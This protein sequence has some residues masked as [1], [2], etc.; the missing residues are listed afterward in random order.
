M[1]DI[2]KRLDFHK[3]NRLLAVRSRI[4]DGDQVD[5]ERLRTYHRLVKEYR[6]EGFRV[7]VYEEIYHLLREKCR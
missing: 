7:G 2:G 5:E 6:R 3:R 1:I 4:W